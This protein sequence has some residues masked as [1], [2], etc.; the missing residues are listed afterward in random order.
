MLDRFCYNVNGMEPYHDFLAQ[1]GSIRLNLFTCYEGK[2]VRKAT[3]VMACFHHHCL[4]VTDQARTVIVFWGA[5]C[6]L[7]SAEALVG[8]GVLQLGE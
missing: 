5:D 2:R 8:E 6:R 3:N 7:C 4:F 1:F